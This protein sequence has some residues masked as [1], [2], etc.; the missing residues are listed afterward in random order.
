MY[1]GQENV[2][3]FLELIQ[4]LPTLQFLSICDY[5]ITDII[6]PS[7]FWNDINTV[8]FRNLSKLK[9]IQLN[10]HSMHRTR[11]FTLELLP[12]LEELCIENDCLS[13]YSVDLIRRAIVGDSTHVSVCSIGKKF[14]LKGSC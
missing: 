6:V 3:S 13:E 8:Y 10:S 2:G 7:N 5:S 14:V 1:L 12:S 4:S 9:S 11:A